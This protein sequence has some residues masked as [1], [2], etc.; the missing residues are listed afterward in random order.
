MF[1]CL[2]CSQL[3]AAVIIN[4]VLF[5]QTGG[6]GASD[7]DEFV[8]LF[9]NGATAIDLSNYVLADGSI[10]PD[11]TDGV[12]FTFPVGSSIPAG[13]YVVVW[14]G[15]STNPDNNASGASSQFWL[16][17]A[18][19]FNNT[20]D[21][22]RL[23]DNT[24]TLIDFVGYGSPSASAY[25]GVSAA[26][27]DTSN[28]TILDNTPKGTS[29]SLTPNGV[30]GNTSTCWTRTAGSDAI[31]ACPNTVTLDTD[32]VFNG[33]NQRVS[34]VGRNNNQASDISVIKSDSSTSYTPGSS[35]T[36]QLQVTNDGPDD[37]AGLLIEDILPNGVSFNG[38]I[39][40]S[41]AA[42]CSLPVTNPPAGQTLSFTLDVT[43][44][45]TVIVSVSIL[46]SINP[47]DY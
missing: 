43:N 12:N 9:N 23:Y 45:Q 15:S 3:N 33:S 47:S 2:I 14:I 39:S 46:F 36:Y 10:A 28:N 37:V 24:G 29:I 18:A 30:D 8:E 26:I 34:S 31:A 1:F 17:S 44:G 20:A 19:Q 4:E 27:W 41:P 21:D 16:N 32:P 5:D 42:A 38:A 11:T 35:A 6:A 25:D 7:N 22:V 13:G 40:C